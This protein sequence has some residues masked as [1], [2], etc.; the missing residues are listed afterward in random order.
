MCGVMPMISPGTKVPLSP[1][2]LPG[3]LSCD[4]G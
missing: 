2:E 1:T 4:M 3:A